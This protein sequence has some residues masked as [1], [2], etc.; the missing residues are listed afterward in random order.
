M[1][2]GASLELHRSGR[3]EPRHIALK[4]FY[5]G[6]RQVSIEEA[7]VLVAIHIP[8]GDPSK[9]SFFRSYK[10]AR[11]RD[12]S[13]GIVSAG[14]HVVLDQSDSTEN[15]WKIHSVCF[16]FGGMRSKTIVATQTQEHLI[17]LPWSKETIDQA[18]DSLL[19][20]MPLDDASPGGQSEYR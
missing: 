19:N 16:A 13:K 15:P 3:A 18:Y 1:S 14:F 17:G 8:I 2:A 11:R 10:Q 5:L 20:E 7:E 4:D 12:D 6:D 9:K